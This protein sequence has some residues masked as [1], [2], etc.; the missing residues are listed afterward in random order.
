M[1]SVKIIHT[2]DLHLDCSFS[3]LSAQKSKIRR[4]EL[5]T[6]FSDAL[7]KYSDARIVLICGDIFDNASFMK[8]SVVFLENLFR[9]YPDTTFFISLGN[10]DPY[11]SRAGDVFKN[12]MPENV[13]VFSDKAEYMEL[14]DIKVRVYGMSFSEKYQ[15]Q[16]MMDEFEVIDD[17][18]I[19]ILMLHA[20][21]V[22][23]MS[24]S[25]YNP[26]TSE[27]IAS[28][29][30]DYIAL[31]HVHEFDG[32]HLAGHTYYAYSGVHE[33]HGFDEC[34][35]KGIIYGNVSKSVCR[36]SLK[37]T[38]MREYVSVSQDVSG[39]CTDEDITAIVRNIVR[40]KDNL[41]RI[42]LTGILNDN[43]SV[44]C[45]L[46][47]N[48]VDA[49][50]VKIEDKTRHNYNLDEI[51]SENGLRAYV[52]KNVLKELQICNEDEVDVIFGASDYLF[53]LIENNGGAR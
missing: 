6:S 47:E 48:S 45:S 46:L 2:G 35:R 30:F 15:Y 24:E 14:D 8:N 53:E 42:T 43:V 52:A 34:G 3:G 40:D 18:Y 50:Y 11:T 41:Y 49:F 22:S 29:G 19:N 12:S 36:L 33:P 4:Q 1:E 20:D 31:G 5:K 32:V 23:N 26:V 10:H 16:S 7:E 21:L 9:S 17:D 25:K 39:A 44:D 51:S 38:A 37:D 13:V 27:K 28:S